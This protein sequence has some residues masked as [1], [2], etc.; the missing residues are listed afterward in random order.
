MYT[1]LL[2]SHHRS[3][4]ASA[5]T[6][7]ELLNRGEYE[8]ALTHFQ[9]DL[10]ADSGELLI[11]QAVCL[12]HL[13]RAREALA[14]CD[15]VLTLQPQHPQGWLF[16]GVALHRLGRYQE[17]YACYHRAVDGPQPAAARRSRRPALGQ[18]WQGL[19]GG[20]RQGVKGALGRLSV[21]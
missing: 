11:N 15:R 2:H 6:A 14:L 18:L 4:A 9:Q 16:K 21:H 19:S 20:L 12:I 10:N 17:A 8:A 7:I 3:V 5:E 13:G 1:D